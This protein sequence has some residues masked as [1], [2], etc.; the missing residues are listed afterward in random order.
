MLA[1]SIKRNKSVEEVAAES[2]GEFSQEEV[3]T[4]RRYK[5]CVQ[6]AIDTH[7]VGW[8]E[9]SETLMKEVATILLKEMQNEFHVT[10]I[11]RHK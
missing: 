6:K 5:K 10:P 1:E 4:Q 7:W 3:E 9:K 2:N 8:S 11:K